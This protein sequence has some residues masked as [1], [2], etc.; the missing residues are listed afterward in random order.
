MAGSRDDLNSTRAHIRY[1]LLIGSIQ[2]AQSLTWCGDI[3]PVSA[4]LSGDIEQ[5]IH[6][7]RKGKPGIKHVGAGIWKDIIISARLF[8]SPEN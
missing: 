8:F 5:E 6:L 7:D 4:R 3:I 2:M 1:L